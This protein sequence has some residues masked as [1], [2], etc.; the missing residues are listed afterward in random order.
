[1]KVVGDWLCLT[2]CAAPSATGLGSWLGAATWYW[3]IREVYVPLSQITC[4]I[5]KGVRDHLNWAAN[6]KSN[7]TNNQQPKTNNNH[8]RPKAT[9]HTHYSKVNTQRA[10]NTTPVK[11]CGAK[12]LT[13][14]LILDQ[15]RRVYRQSVA[16]RDRQ[17]SEYHLN[18]LWHSCRKLSN[19]EPDAPAQTLQPATM[20]KKEVSSDK[21]KKK[22]K[23][24]NSTTME[25][26][27]K[28][29]QK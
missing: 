3:A 5:F 12:H 4:V 23:S 14:T 15:T 6:D 18:N 11:K 17:T 25:V 28:P 2:D 7:H 13:A 16:G 29:Y 19:L 20:V 27:F 21:A 8:Q 26:T 22:V 24:E 1:L 9:Q 10:D